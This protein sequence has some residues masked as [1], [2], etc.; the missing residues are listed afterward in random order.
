M[1]VF[2][3]VFNVSFGKFIKNW[4]LDPD[5]ISYTMVLVSIL[6]PFFD[7]IIQ[8]LIAVFVLLLDGLDGY[9]ARK[10]GK[11]DEIID[12]ACDRASEIAMFIRSPFLLSLVV[13]NSILAGL[14]KK[15]QKWYIRP[16]ILRFLFIAWLFLNL[17]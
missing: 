1:G 11:N 13:I 3:G 8:L 14:N 5:K 2:S 12:D 6:V 7:G 16:F 17:L 4:T 10:I 9:M 15:F